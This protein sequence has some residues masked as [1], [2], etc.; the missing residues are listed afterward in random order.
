M[1]M[2]EKTYKFVGWYKGKTKPT[3]LTT[4]ATPNYLATFDDN[5]DMTAVYEEETPTAALTLTST[6]R[7]VHSGDNVDW[8]ATLKNTS[9]APLKTMTVKPTTAWPAGIG[10]PTSLSVQLEGQAPK[11]YPVTATTWAKG[12]SLTGLEIPAGQTA[13]VTL[14]DTEISGTSDQRFTATLDVT[15]NF[16]TVSASDAVRLTDTTQGTAEPTAEGF[17]SVPSF[18]FGKINIASITKQSGLKK[19]S[20]YYENGTRNPYLRIKKNQPNW[21]ITAQLSQ[22]K[23]TTDSLPTATRL[24]LGAASVSSFTHYNEATEQIKAVGNTNSLSLT[25]N[26]VATSIVADQQFTGSDVY[27]LDFQFD[28]I[29]LEVPANQGTKGKHY[30]AA[31]TW[32]LVTGP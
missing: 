32:N 9:L 1:Q 17:I 20:D 19:A 26:N 7:V 4:T 24:L 25:A 22:P 15:G 23:A 10:A 29:K 11:V 16:A 27:Q 6:N 12:I 13:N 18:D 30:T 2:G 31:V 21:R 3:T 5:D 28:N 8:V 14:V